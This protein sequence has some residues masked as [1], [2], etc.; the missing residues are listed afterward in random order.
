MDSV[1]IGKVENGGRELIIVELFGIPLASSTHKVA[2]YDENPEEFTKRWREY[3]ARQIVST[4]AEK[5]H[6]ERRITG[7]LMATPLSPVPPGLST[8][9]EGS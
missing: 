2:E 6:R 4:V 7:W 3:F 1:R 5:M 9:G 8:E